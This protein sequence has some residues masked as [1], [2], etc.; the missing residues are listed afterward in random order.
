M[1]HLTRWLGAGIV[2]L[3]G[4]GCVAANFPGQPSAGE[5]ARDLIADE[6]PRLTR[7]QRADDGPVVLAQATLPAQ[8]SPPTPSNS[9]SIP[10]RVAAPSPGLG[11]L[12]PG[13]PSAQNFG[14][15]PVA[16]PV[17]LPAPPPGLPTSVAGKNAPLPSLPTPTTVGV[18][19]PSAPSVGGMSLPPAP[20]VTG[21]GGAQ[22]ASLKVSRSGRVAVRAW[23]NGRP[24]FDDEVVLLLEMSNPAAIR[25]TSVERV[26]QAYN[27]TLT[28][29]IELEIA[30]QDAVKKLE[31]GNPKMLDK[32]KDLVSQD[33]DKQART[34]RK[35]VPEDKFQEIAPTFRRQIERQYIGM[36][37]IRSMVYSKV[38]GVGF[39]EV[40]DYYDTHLNEFQKVESVKWQH[41][42]IALNAQRPTVADAN[43]FAQGLIAQLPSGKDFATLTKYD[44]GDSK[45][46]D[47]AGFGNRKGDIQP[48]EL[49][50][51]LFEMKDGQIGPIIA[52]STGVHLFRLVQREVGGQMPLNEAVQTQIRNKIRNQIFE[53]EFKRFIKDL[54]TRADVQFA[55]EP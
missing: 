11:N 9:L 35:S 42:F 49:E 28:S 18:N 8:S 6:M 46:R 3:A 52:V 21:P 31:K 32:L 19:L 29:I 37:Y 15:I 44:D 20:P 45:T 5:L 51:Y 24:I 7:M 36:E 12:P 50:K 23:V 41:V 13:P 48:A 53:R 39:L 16:P 55:A 2:S 17:N 33:Y 38:N 47:G 27:Q 43:R 34:I 40:K 10:T 4:M 25:D 22:Q 1:R 54:K 14:S 26:T 30:Y